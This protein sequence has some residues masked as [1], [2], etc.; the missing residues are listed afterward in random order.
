M[1]ELG[2]LD[3]SVII[4]LPGIDDDRLP[5]ESAITAVTLAELAAGLHATSCSDLTRC[6]RGEA[7]DRGAA[8][9]SGVSP[10]SV[11]VRDPGGKR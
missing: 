8:T 9:K 1:A 10:L 2:I 5:D 6:S 3:T 7:A 11:V 4:D